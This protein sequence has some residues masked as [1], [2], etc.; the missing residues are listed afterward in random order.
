MMRCNYGNKRF[1]C[2]HQIIHICISKIV[3]ELTAFLHLIDVGV[4]GKFFYMGYL[5]RFCGAHY[6]ILVNVI[7]LFFSRFLLM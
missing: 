2:D 5:R 4:R 6:S 1:V 7:S 3:E